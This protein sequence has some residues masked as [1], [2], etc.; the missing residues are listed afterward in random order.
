M[1]SNWP[2][3]NISQ[4]KLLRR[5]EYVC[6]DCYNKGNTVLLCR[7]DKRFH[8]AFHWCMICQRIEELEWFDVEK[9]ME[10]KRK[11]IKKVK[12]NI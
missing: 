6:P 4:Y 2:R 9:A 5:L 11:P 10:E 8:P 3:I 12:E 7:R 1:I